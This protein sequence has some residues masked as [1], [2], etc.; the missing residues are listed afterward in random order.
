MTVIQT[1]G[2]L[3]LLFGFTPDDDLYI[4]VVTD[5][6]AIAPFHQSDSEYLPVTIRIATDSTDFII[7]TVLDG[8]VVDS[9]TISIYNETPLPVLN[10][11]LFLNDSHVSVVINGQWVYSFAFAYVSYPVLPLTITASLQVHA[12]GGAST[13]LTNIIRREFTESRDAVYI[14]YESNGQSAIGS[15]IQERPIQVLPQPTRA[16]GFT[17]RLVKDSVPAHHIYYYQ[18]NEQNNAD[19]SSDGLVYF[20]DIGISQNL[21][22]AREVGFVTKLYRLSN[23]NTAGIQAAYVLQQRALQGR[24]PI[25]LKQRVDPRVEITDHMPISIVAS[26]TQREITD[27]VIVESASIHIADGS[28]SMDIQGRRNL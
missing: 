23:L 20:Y 26:G 13:E 10:V 22:A 6:G 18:A 16:Y 24:H 21:N 14:D 15:V 5:V 12:T 3:E 7:S 28:Y 8:A 11:R 19:V 4:D 17:Y 25:T 27:D 1:F 9:D 2:G